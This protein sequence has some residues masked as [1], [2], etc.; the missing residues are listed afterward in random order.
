MEH[1]EKEQGAAATVRSYPGLQVEE[2]P[3]RNKILEIQQGALRF[4]EVEKERK[5]QLEKEQGAAA[6]SSVV[7]GYERSSPLVVNFSQKERSSPK[8]AISVGDLVLVDQLKIILEEHANHI[9]Q[10][11]EGEMSLFRRQVCEKVSKEQKKEIYKQVSSV[12]SINREVLIGKITSGL[13]EVE[14]KLYKRLDAQDKEISFLKKRLEEREEEVKLDIDSLHDYGD[15]HTDVLKTLW[16]KTMGERFP[17][18]NKK[19]ALT[20]EICSERPVDIVFNPCGHLNC[21]E[22]CYIRVAAVAIEE[23]EKVRCP[24]CRREIEGTIRVFY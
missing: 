21:C 16:A 8:D 7:T 13:R 9:N 6:N 14:D 10:Q 5:R 18:R 19:P 20:C 24:T 4:I 23:D 1:L 22:H 2:V 12:E 3:A 11:V 17:N 15:Y